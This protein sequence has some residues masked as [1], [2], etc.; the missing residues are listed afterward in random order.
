MFLTIEDIKGATKT[1]DGQ[2]PLLVLG[3]EGAEDLRFAVG[4]VVSLSEEFEEYFFLLV[5]P[6]PQL[7][8]YPV[9]PLPEIFYDSSNQHLYKIKDLIAVV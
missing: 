5:V 4:D 8:P 7:L 9:D 3:V 6:G 1:G 2:D